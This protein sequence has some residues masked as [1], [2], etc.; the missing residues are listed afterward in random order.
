MTIFSELSCE[1]GSEHRQEMNTFLDQ[2]SSFYEIDP[3]VS[4]TDNNISQRT[5]LWKFD[6]HK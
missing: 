3:L 6:L 5:M 4:Q 2:I 1:L